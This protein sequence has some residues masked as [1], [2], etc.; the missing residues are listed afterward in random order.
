MIAAFRKWIKDSETIAWARLQV[1]LGV[2]IGT[3]MALDPQ[4]VG[5]VLPEKWVPFWFLFSGVVTEIA[6]RARAKD[7]K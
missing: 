6:R 3:L 2:V 1:L 7:L 5:A 4:L